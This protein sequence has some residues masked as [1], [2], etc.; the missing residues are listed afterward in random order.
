M[1]SSALP[2]H[3]T[4][5]G[6][7]F[8]DGT[9]IPADVIVFSTGFEGNMR[10]EVARLFGKDVAARADDFWGLDEEGELKGAFKRNSRMFSPSPCIHPYISIYSFRAT[11]PGY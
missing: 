4:T 5:T 10:S 3:Y 1:K 7:A 6:L 8:S 9:E 2:T 11:P